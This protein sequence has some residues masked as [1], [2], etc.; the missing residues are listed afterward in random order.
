MTQT[1]TKTYTVTETTVESF[2]IEVPAGLQGDDLDDYIENERVNNDHKR[3]FVA[4][5]DVGWEEK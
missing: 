4:V 2:E 3:Q 1:K 5:T